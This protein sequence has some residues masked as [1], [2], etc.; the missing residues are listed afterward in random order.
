MDQYIELL[1]IYI[2]VSLTKTRAHKNQVMGKF[3]W[4]SG[5][6]FNET[7]SF[8]Y[9]KIGRKQYMTPFFY[10]GKR[11]DR[12]K[13]KSGLHA[14]QQFCSTKCNVETFFLMRLGI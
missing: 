4:I 2:A 8:P 14:V 9:R 10:V 5:P 13:T 3:P 1:K 12:K 6:G 11:C 7:I